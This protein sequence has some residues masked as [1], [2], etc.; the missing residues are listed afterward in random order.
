MP[1]MSEAEK[2]K[3]HKRILDAAARILRAQGVEAISVADVMKAAGMT[4]GG[5]YRHFASREDLVAAA[6]DHA[7]ESVLGPVEAEKAERD[8]EAVA[9]YVSD[10]LSDAHRRNRET[11][12]PLAAIAGEA[13]RDDGPVR[14][15]TE[16]AARRTALVLS[17]ATG[18]P[19]SEEDATDELGLATLS[20]LVGTIVLSRLFQEDDDAERL[21][22]LGQSSVEILRDHYTKPARV[23]GN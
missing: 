1:R 10:Y 22:K 13:L 20:V 9:A 8:G 16:R 4:H 21:L 5:F 19:D 7:A 15:A 14:D 17:G 11:G 3:S 23:L 6:I 12:C 2:Q 18:A